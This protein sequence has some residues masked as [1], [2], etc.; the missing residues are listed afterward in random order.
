MLF[1]DSWVRKEKI[2]VPRKEIMKE[3]AGKKSDGKNPPI[4]IEG[5]INALLR[6]GYIR[7]GYTGTNQ[8]TFVQLRN[9]RT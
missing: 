4:T 1:V 6:K 2:P 3:F 8:T 7:R 9:I 5:A